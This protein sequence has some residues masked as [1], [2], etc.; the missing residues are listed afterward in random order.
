MKNRTL[1]ILKIKAEKFVDKI[2]GR[3]QLLPFTVG[4]D[5]EEPEK[6][7][8]LTE[9][10]YL[11]YNAATGQYRADYKPNGSIPKESID[12]RTAKTLDEFTPVKI[13]G[14]VSMYIGGAQYMF[15]DWSG[16]MIPIIV[17]SVLSLDAA[18]VT[19]TGGM[20]I[21]YDGLPAVKVFSIEKER[22]EK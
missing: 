13:K 21:N 17:D 2:T 8:E 20:I 7:K 19:I 5:K 6:P 12:I 15:K 18:L 9:D 1:N 3:N 11:P 4:V 22:I 16:E 10:D 14:V